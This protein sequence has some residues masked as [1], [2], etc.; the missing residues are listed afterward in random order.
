MFTIRSCTSPGLATEPPE[1]TPDARRA[2]QRGGAHAVRHRLVAQRR[3][4]SIARPTRARARPAGLVPAGTDS[5]HDR[6]SV[7]QEA[8]RD[9]EGGVYIVPMMM[10]TGWIWSTQIPH[11]L[12]LSGA[13]SNDGSRTVHLCDPLGHHP[14]LGRLVGLRA[15][16]AARRHGLGKRNGRAD[17][18]SWDGSRP[19]FSARHRPARGAA[20]RDGRVRRDRDRLPGPS[21]DDSGYRRGAGS[22]R[23]SSPGC[24]P[25]PARTRSKT[26]LASSP[27]ATRPT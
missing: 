4:S 13:S 16:A 1:L 21:P 12:G 17:R 18:R 15:Q 6:W 25:R 9:L 8:L 5:R 23:R 22:G 19:G 20:A 7:P 27:R 11:A 10:C 26:C 14:E 24:S 2:F 3:A